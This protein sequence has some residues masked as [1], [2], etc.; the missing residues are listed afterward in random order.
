MGL[1][2]AWRADPLWIGYSCFSLC[3]VNGGRIWVRTE[4]GGGGTNE[5]I[6]PADIKGYQTEACG[7]HKYVRSA[8]ISF[9]S[10]R[11]AKVPLRLEASRIADFIPCL[12]TR[13]QTCNLQGGVSGRW[14]DFMGAGKE[15]DLFNLLQ[16]LV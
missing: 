8:L 15:R 11:S 14:E 3:C 6:G 16:I 5:V 13:R 7:R 10:W 12:L 1:S 2:D 4:S 9:C